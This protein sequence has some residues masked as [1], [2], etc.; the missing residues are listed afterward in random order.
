MMID[1]KEVKASK[2][3]RRKNYEA[4]ESMQKSAKAFE[5]VLRKPYATEIGKVEVVEDGEQAHIELSI[6][7]AVTATRCKDKNDK[8]AHKSMGG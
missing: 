8:A 4:M 1:N 2:F 6:P 7:D 3:E 5:R